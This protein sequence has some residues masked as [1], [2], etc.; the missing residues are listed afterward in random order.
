LVVRSVNA[1]FLAQTQ[2]NYVQ[3]N[4]TLIKVHF[5]LSE[6]WFSRRSK[7]TESVLFNIDENVTG[8]SFTIT[9]DS[10]SKGC[11]FVSGQPFVSYVW[12]GTE[13]CFVPY[14]GGFWVA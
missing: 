5:T 12:N 8:F 13:N 3:V 14:E 2:P 9:P 1:S 6:N 4:S 10:W 11:L 7:T